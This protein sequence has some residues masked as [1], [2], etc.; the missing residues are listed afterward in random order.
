MEKRRLIALI[1]AL[2]MAFALAARGTGGATT[3]TA[4][5]GPETATGPVEAEEAATGQ[6]GEEETTTGPE[7]AEG[8]APAAGGF[9]IALIT[10]YGTIDDRS[11]NQGSWEGVVQFALP[12]GIAHRYYQ[13]PEVSPEA[14]IATIELAVTGGARIIVT[15]GFLFE[16]SIFIAQDRFP[17][18]HFIL[19]DG[20]PRNEGWT[21]FRTNDNVVAI[22]YAEEEAGFL[23]GYAAV[24][25]GN[26]SLGFMGGMAVPAVV[27]F[28]YGF[29]QGAEFAAQYMGL[30]SESIQ[31][32]Y[33][34]TGGFSATP[35][36]QAMAASWYNA[37][38]EVV[39]ACG[40]LL[41]NSVMAAAEAAG[42]KVIGVDVD[43]SV[44][45]ETV[46]TS[47]LKGLTVSVYDSLAAFYD[48]TFPGGQNL[49]FR[50]YNYG[51]GLPMETSKFEVF[52]QADYDA[53]FQR[54][55]RNEIPLMRDVDDGGGFVTIDMLPVDAVVLRTF[56]N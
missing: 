29:V 51:V 8:A 39:F 47:A 30:G 4:A 10:D 53:V 1:V 23:A 22:T 3:T 36:V 18:I 50:A 2:A 55:Q 38:I 54:L 44:E 34:Y 16:E 48:G 43:Q 12:R 9:E 33:H 17:D 13:P 19:L 52:G 5:P 14:Y 41:G 35:E 45:S 32:Y 6:A 40:G 25:D 49:V 7:A 24:R 37:G 26:T 21:E 31:L 15:P 46:I 20:T 42:T 27:R 11:F 56:A 28:G